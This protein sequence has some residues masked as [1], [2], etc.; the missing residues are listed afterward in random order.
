MLTR[1]PPSVR[2]FVP[3]LDAL[4]GRRLM[5]ASDLDPGFGNGGVVNLTGTNRRGTELVEAYPGGKML[6]AREPQGNAFGGPLDLERYDASGQLDPSFGNGGVATFPT[7]VVPAT[8][9]AVVRDVDVMADGRILVTGGLLDTTRT[10]W[11]GGFI[12]RFNPN[13]QLDTTFGQSGLARY[14]DGNAGIWSVA[15]QPDG[16]IV[17]GGTF[18]HHEFAAARF[19]STG[20]IDTD[21]GSGGFVS[22]SFVNNDHVQEVVVGAD[23]SITAI[24]FILSGSECELGVARWTSQGESDPS[25]GTGGS[26]RFFIGP[27]AFPDIEAHLLPGGKILFSAADLNRER[28]Q[29]VQILPGGQLDPSFGTGGILRTSIIRGPAFQIQADGKFLVAGA[30]LEPNLQETF[31]VARYLPDGRL[32]PDFGTSGMATYP[33]A[34]YATAGYSAA[35]QPGGQIV[36]AGSSMII[37]DKG[38]YT[39]AT[40]L[41]RLM[42]DRGTVGIP[43][44]QAGPAKGYSLVE[45][46]SLRLDASASSDPGG[47]PLMYAWDLNGDGRFNDAFGAKPVVPWNYLVSFGTRQPG[48]Y[49]ARVQINDGQGHIVTSAAVPVTIQPFQT[50]IAAGFNGATTPTGNVETISVAFNQATNLGAL[51]ANG[52]IANAVMLYRGTSRI[53]IAPGRFRYDAARRVLTLDVTRDAFGPDRTSNL[54]AGAYELRLAISLIKAEGA[55]GVTLHD[56]DG[57]IDG[58]RRFRFTIPRKA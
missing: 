6:L 54:P 24:G 33:M 45:G 44:A 39:Y 41:A 32:D 30:R 1:K 48:T 42:G 58:L 53:S 12:A 7:D 26:T 31:A 18:E 47:G 5:A 55:P 43:D 17:A 10:G 36:V 37:D 9:A 51:I 52:S 35:F 34:G 4:E 25:F 8:T 29:L 14:A 38:N 21:F 50:S 57:L 56:T 28:L 46:S 13:G 27:S 15:V 20:Q 2:R 40:R 22:A 23:G 3:V 11:A 16:K 49:R 19:T